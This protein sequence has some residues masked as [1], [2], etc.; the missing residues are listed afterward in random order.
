MKPAQSDPVAERPPAAIV[1]AAL[2]CRGLPERAAIGWA[3]LLAWPDWALAARRAA[4]ERQ[5]L[6][7]GA[8]RHVDALRGCIAGPVLSS[9]GAC[10]GA[11]AL[12]A[13][14]AG[15]VPAVAQRAALPAREQLADTWRAAGRELR[16]AGVPQGTLRAA[17]LGALGWQEVEPA[18]VDAAALDAW[19]AGLP[20]DEA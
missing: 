16:F 13:L 15:P 1:E 20:D 10:L 11:A 3:E 19:L 7:C 5:V 6:R 18:E 12:K 2:A 14:L 8:L 17:L 9:A 4:L